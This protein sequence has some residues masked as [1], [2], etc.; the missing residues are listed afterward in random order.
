MRILITND[1]GIRAAQ[2]IPLVRWA[3][4]H[5]E[6]VVAAPKVEQS[7]KS[8]GIEIHKAFEVKKEELIPG[9]TGYAV[10]STPADCVRFAV[11]GLGERFDLV[12]SGINRGLNIGSDIMY[13]GTVS[14][15]MEAYALGIRAV[16]L[17]TEPHYYGEAVKHL[18]DV[19]DFFTRN[20]LFVHHDLYNV[21]I[22][23]NPGA[24]RITRQGGPYYS[25]DFLPQEHDLYLPHGKDIFTAS[26]TME[27]DTD[28]VLRGH[29]ISVTPLTVDRTDLV[30]YQKLLTLNEKEK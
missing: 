30:M 2:L 28:A 9:V 21:N 16:A 18:D 24:F 7:G 3:Q 14:A 15:V 22:P 13:S 19:W 4:K 26:E 1:D 29:L 17:S 6:V 20:D 25:D 8:H 5:G 27:R 23:A 11:L 12:I 10:D